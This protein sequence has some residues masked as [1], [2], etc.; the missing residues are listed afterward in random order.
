M[1]LCFY[2]FSCYNSLKISET[3]GQVKNLLR[4]KI[5]IQIKVTLFGNFYYFCTVCE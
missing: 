4:I 1:V 5:K 3:T 2:Q